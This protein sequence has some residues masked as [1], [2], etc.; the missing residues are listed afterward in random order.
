MKRVSTWEVYNGL[1]GSALW[2]LA[3]NTRAISGEKMSF[4]GR[5]WHDQLDDNWG[6]E[7]EVIIDRN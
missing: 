6:P 2:P 3:E 5:E 1:P 4:H 7:K